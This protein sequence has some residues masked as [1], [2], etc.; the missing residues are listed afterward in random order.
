MTAHRAKKQKI[1]KNA[2]FKHIFSI[3]GK[4]LFTCNC[5][6]EMHG[7]NITPGPLCLLLKAGKKPA[8]GVTTFFSDLL[9]PHLS[10]YASS[11][12]NKTKKPPHCNTKK[13]DFFQPVSHKRLIQ[14]ADNNMLQHKGHFNRSF[15]NIGFLLNLI[16][17]CCNEVDLPLT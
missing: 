8:E 10:Y 4:E 12:K 13:P 9:I 5:S 11:E 14:K 15:K 2:Y 3:F 1:I 16:T 7:D 17:T 6:Q